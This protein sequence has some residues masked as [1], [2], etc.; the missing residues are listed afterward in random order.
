[1]TIN[2][3]GKLIEFNTPK[4]LGILNVTPDSFYDGGNLK[5]EKAIVEKTQ[6]MFQEGADFIDVGGYSS[7]PGAKNIS[8]EEEK[9]RV[10]PIVKMLK[11]EFPDILLSI[12]T[13]RSEVAKACLDVGAS[14]IN[15][16]AASS[17]DVQM[18]QTVAQYQV[19]YIMMHMKGTPQTM[20]SL[21]NYKNVTTEVCFYFSEKIAE[22]RALGIND[23]VVDAG[24]GFA[25]TVVHNFE[26]LNQLHILQ[27]L[28]VPVLTGVSRKSMIYKTLNCTAKE[29]LN[30]TTALHMVA[31]Q[32]GS[33][34]LRVHD[35]KEAKQCILLHEALKTAQNA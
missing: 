17:L 18:M 27:Q 13:F 26:L 7:R 1:M 20:K 21:A 8:I 34:I 30:G 22:A 3:H 29:A 14:V 5:N 4:I 11:K 19:P 9:N 23:I 35:V 31:L 16:I 12:D 6:Q 25:K 28:D 2:C 32:K 15:D 33:N 24:F 10:V